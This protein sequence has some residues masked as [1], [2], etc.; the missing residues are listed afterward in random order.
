VVSIDYISSLINFEVLTFFFF[1]R[2][3]APTLRVLLGIDLPLHR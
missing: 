2:F 1:L 3:E